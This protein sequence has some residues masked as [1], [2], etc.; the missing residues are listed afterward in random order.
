VKCNVM[1]QKTSF[2]PK[3]KN[4]IIKIKGSGPGV[5][6]Q[7]GMKVRMTPIPQEVHKQKTKKIVTYYRHCKAWT[8]R[9]SVERFYQT[10]N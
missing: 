3:D 8:S 6:L 2:N 10:D 7:I 9:T 1:K 5:S 4:T